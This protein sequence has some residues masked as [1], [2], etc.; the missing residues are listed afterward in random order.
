[1]YAGKLWNA[2]YHW[3]HYAMAPGMTVFTVWCITEVL[4]GNVIAWSYFLL[5]NWIFSPLKTIVSCYSENY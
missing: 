1:M 2:I 4:P 5:C 3:I